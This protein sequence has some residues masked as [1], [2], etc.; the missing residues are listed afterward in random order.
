[1]NGSDFALCLPVAGVAHETA[2]SLHAALAA[3]PALRAGRA[4]VAV[5]GVEGAQPA[6]PGA[7]LAA[8]DDALAQAEARG[9]SGY[10]PVVV[11]AWGGA[12]E[13][14]A[15]GGER[16]WRAQIAAALA[17]GRVQLQEVPVLD[18]AGHCA[19]LAC[20]LSVQTL[21]GGPYQAAEGWLAW[22]RRSRL[23][24]LVD[25]A[26]MELALQAI[27]A[28]GKARAVP[29][30]AQSLLSPGFI[31][32]AAELLAA[33]PRAAALLTVECTDALREAAA[34][35]ALAAAARAWRAWGVRMGVGPMNELALH[36]PALKAAG[37]RHV[38]LDARTLPGLAGDEALRG[39]VRGLADLVHGLGL[40]VLAS[41][42]N[43]AAEA[44]VLWGLGVDATSGAV[45]PPA[46]EPALRR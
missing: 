45:L 36:L 2:S 8:A 39:Y 42:V 43:D 26:C 25:A 9:A 5:G 3:V 12:S 40:T 17:D 33:R 32:E 46:P 28:D 15:E 18:A 24:P 44:Q 22:A 23:L 27:A 30:S 13:R 20:R 19:H 21:P 7:V 38:T 31:T 34:L 16:A 14:N 29:A 37:V 10:S 1:L 4:D 41:A 6:T 35:P 11:A